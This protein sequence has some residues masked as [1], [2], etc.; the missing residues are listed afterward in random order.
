M[1]TAYRNRVV[2]GRR[3]VERW[4]MLATVLAV[5]A[6]GV[7]FAASGS[8]L[9]KGLLWKLEPPGAA[10]S[11]LFGT[12][13]SDDPAVARLALPVQQ[14]FDRSEAVILEV[15]LDA[16]TI[17]SLGASMQM[18]DCDSLESVLGDALYRRAAAAM[19]RQGIP[20]TVVARMKPWAV[21]VTLMM[22]PADS[23]V[24]LDQ[25]LYEAAIAAKKQVA[26]LETVA[27]QMA[28]FD[29]LSR[30]DQITLLED[31]L[32]HLPEIGRELEELLQAWRDRDL[33]RLM[34]ISDEYLQQGNPRLAAMFNQRVLV[35]RNHR[36]A[37]RLQPY[38][39]EGR[40]FVAVGA[41]HLPGEQ[42]LLNLLE[43]RGYK[44]TRL[45]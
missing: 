4:R 29:G 20:E 21:A 15:A 30:Q 5:C 23:G 19:H 24:V 38:L 1:T 9:D 37:N 28:L 18:T 17:H 43:Q 45:Y 8:R 14:A 27:E 26:G 35:D 40:F 36:M 22:P 39:R 3:T 12:I 11:Y 25:R 34:A 42:G 10:A 41:L 6:M 2:N 16:R 44:L 31:T 32:D 33:G 13:H 7:A